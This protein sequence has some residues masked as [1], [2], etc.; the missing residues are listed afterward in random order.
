M[1]QALTTPDY[2]DFNLYRPGILVKTPGDS[3]ESKYWSTHIPWS[4]EMALYCAMLVMSR[5]RHPEEKV[6]HDLVTL[7]F[8]KRVHVKK[9]FASDLKRI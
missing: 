1:R 2:D 9:R 4:R 6:D 3:I 7:T 8:C 5:C